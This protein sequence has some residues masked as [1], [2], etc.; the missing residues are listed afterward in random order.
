MSSSISKRLDKLQKQITG[1]SDNCMVT[2][3]FIDGSK[4]TVPYYPDF[5]G[6][7]TDD[8]EVVE[9]EIERRGW[10]GEVVAIECDNW[11]YANMVALLEAMWKPNSESS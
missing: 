10:A 4:V 1:G 9:S 2:V 6:Y 5:T 7:I 11:R 3:E 8:G